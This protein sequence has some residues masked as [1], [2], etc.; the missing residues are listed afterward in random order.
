ME[1]KV[2]LSPDHRQGIICGVA[3]ARSSL[4]RI[5]PYAS[6]VAPRRLASDALLVTRNCSKRASGLGSGNEAVDL[7]YP[8]HVGG[9]ALHLIVLE[10]LGNRFFSRTLLEQLY[11]I[12][13]LQW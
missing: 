5:A 1:G 13:G 7:G 9:G 2:R 11:W 4:R 3:F 6:V 12:G 8:G 10:K